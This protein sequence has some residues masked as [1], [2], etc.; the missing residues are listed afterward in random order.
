[1]NNVQKR[2]TQVYGDSG[3]DSGDY[4]LVSLLLLIVAMCVASFVQ[5]V[6]ERFA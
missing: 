6:I 5:Y 4:A 1:M 2:P 3:P